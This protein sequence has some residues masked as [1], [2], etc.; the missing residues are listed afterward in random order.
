V[1]IKGISG[2]ALVVVLLMGMLAACGAPSGP[3]IRAKD[4]WARPAV[5]MMDSGQ[6]SGEGMGTAGTGAIFMRLVNEGKEP[7]RLVG[8]KTDAAKALEVHET[9]MEGDV[10][11]MQMLANGLEVPAQGNVL[12][13]PG[14]YHIMLIG[15]QR[16]L[17]VGDKVTVVLQFEKSGTMTVEAEVREP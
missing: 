17:K 4:V 8:G 10:M 7:D 16:D 3:N 11:K 6:S 2:A 14:S 5:A 15:L 1:N 9:V 12:L 13:K